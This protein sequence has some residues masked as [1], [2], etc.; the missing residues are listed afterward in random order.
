MNSATGSSCAD[1]VY[2]LAQE[3]G[4]EDDIVALLFDTTSVNTGVF[5]GVCI[6]LEQKFGRSLLY[7]AHF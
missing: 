3:Y 2:E 5:N 7:L 4:A 1:A 6:L